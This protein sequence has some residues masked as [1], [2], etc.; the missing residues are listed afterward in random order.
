MTK[1]ESFIFNSDDDKNIDIWVINHR[2][3]KGF[4]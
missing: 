4:L 3:S 2:D 1:S